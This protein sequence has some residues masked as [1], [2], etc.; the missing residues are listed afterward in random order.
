MGTPP[1]GDPKVTHRTTRRCRVHH[2]DCHTAESCLC[3]FEL[4]AEGGGPS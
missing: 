1:P 4:V 3:G 2:P